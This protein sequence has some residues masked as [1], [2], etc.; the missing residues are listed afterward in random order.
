MDL[1]LENIA[2]QHILKH[3]PSPTPSKG[4]TSPL[5]VGIQGP[6]GIGKTT[7]TAQLASTL[8]REPHSLCV[9]TLSIDD[10][11]LG[12]DALKELG[13]KNSQNALLQGRGQ[14]GTH[15]IHLGAETLRGLHEI[16]SQ[17]TNGTKTVLIP[18]YDKSLH[19]GQGDR[20]PESKWKKVKGGVDIVILEGWSLG[21]YPVPLDVIRDRWE[22]RTELG[23]PATVELQNGIHG[24]EEINEKL[25]EYVSGWY[26][27][28]SCFIQV[29]TLDPF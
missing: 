8:S 20:L 6:Q 26:H 18:S 28:L 7:L 25:K 13:N 23:W 3:I 29:Y 1:A 22:K 11:Y 12:H 19:D 15:D 17:G 5:F 27:Y 10:L 24:I 16:N 21:F 9:V 14:P 4:H 2:V